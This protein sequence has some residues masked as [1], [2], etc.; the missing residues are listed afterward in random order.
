MQ[1]LVWLCGKPPKTNIIRAFA[2]PKDKENKRENGPKYICKEYFRIFGF[3]VKVSIISA[4]F[5]LR[6]AC[7]NP[8]I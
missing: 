6:I 5:T 7:A 4:F 3:S 1:N 8:K 2:L